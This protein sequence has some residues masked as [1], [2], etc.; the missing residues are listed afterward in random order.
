M[1][2]GPGGS[3]ALVPATV[4]LSDINKVTRQLAGTGGT[5]VEKPA[6]AQTAYPPS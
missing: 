5:S 4:L 6:E 3:L 2:L 1:I